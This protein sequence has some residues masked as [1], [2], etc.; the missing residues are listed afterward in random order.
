MSYLFPNINY[1][2]NYYTV[3]G[4]EVKYHPN[5]PEEWATNHWHFDSVR[6]QLFETGPEKC[7][8]CA[9]FGTCCGVFIGY[10]SN[11]AEI[12]YN[13]ERGEGCVS[14]FV[15]GE[16]PQ[17]W[18]RLPY[19]QGVNIEDIGL[20]EEEQEEEQEQE[21]IYYP[22]Q[23]E[24]DA[25]YYEP[26]NENEDPYENDRYL[27]RRELR[28]CELPDFEEDNSDYENDYDYQDD[29][30]PYASEYPTPY[31]LCRLPQDMRNGFDPKYAERLEIFRVWAREEV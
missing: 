13:C 1:H 7:E 25:F 11:C 18:S 30:E 20:E 21:I 5:F 4:S 29:E 22:T 10:C 24:I 27:T 28:P 26:K 3:E 16:E 6:V 12:M 15:S 23:E 19:M 9:Y 17:M 2:N 8:N 14:N 31:E